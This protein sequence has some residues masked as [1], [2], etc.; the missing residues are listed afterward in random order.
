MKTNAPEKIYFTST[1]GS[2][3][4]YTE[5]IPFEREY[6]EYVCKE[7]FIEKAITWLKESVTNNTECN[8]IISKKGVSTMGLLI[9]DFKKYMEG[10]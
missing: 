5:A 3:H 6:I 1:E 7:S 9:E 8:R 2:T 4:Y 10:E